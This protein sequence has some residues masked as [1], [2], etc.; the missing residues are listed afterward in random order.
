MPFSMNRVLVWVLVVYTVVVHGHDSH[1]HRHPHHQLE[2]EG[3]KSISSSS[4]QSSSPS[5]ASFSFYDP[6]DSQCLLNP[7]SE[8][9]S[10]IDSCEST[11]TQFSSFGL[12]SMILTLTN[13]TL[14]QWNLTLWEDS[15]CSNNSSR[16][17]LNGRGTICQAIYPGN[18]LFRIST[19]MISN[20]WINNYY[21]QDTC[22]PK[23]IITT[24]GAPIGACLPP[25]VNSSLPWT[26]Q[27]WQSQFYDGQLV[28]FQNF[29]LDTECTTYFSSV[30][31]TYDQC[32]G[33]E[34]FQCNGEAEE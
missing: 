22:N 3:L 16:V 27:Q 19:P 14:N 23:S 2:E 8:F 13:A 30:D 18:L 32:V 1:H 25:P 28:Y 5:A 12:Q 33:G 4:V 6:T 26:G 31:N 10:N 9:P 11:P 15:D 20:C 21:D 17:E 29:Y 24:F 7:T 34:L